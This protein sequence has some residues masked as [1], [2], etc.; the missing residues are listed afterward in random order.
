VYEET[1]AGNGFGIADA[2][3]SI[4]LTHAIRSAAISPKDNLTHPL[5]NQ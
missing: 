4:N 2:R 1:L 5:L 3:P